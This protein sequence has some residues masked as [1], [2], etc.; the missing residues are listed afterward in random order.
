MGEAND[1]V[2][3]PISVATVAVTGGAATA[4]EATTSAEPAAIIGT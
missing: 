3:D 2:F 1:D 4:A